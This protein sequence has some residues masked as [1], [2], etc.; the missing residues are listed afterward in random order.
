MGRVPENMGGVGKNLNRAKFKESRLFFGT[1][2][3]KITM[4]AGKEEENLSYRKK[5]TTV[6][7]MAI[8]V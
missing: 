1:G 6:L 3:G 2:W 7:F 4:S 5:K 8:F